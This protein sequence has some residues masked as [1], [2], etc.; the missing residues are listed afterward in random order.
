MVSLCCNLRIIFSSY[1]K[2][3]LKISKK[4]HTILPL[5]RVDN[6]LQAVHIYKKSN[7]EMIYFLGIF[8]MWFLEVITMLKINKYV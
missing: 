1:K 5:E 2:N 6:V 8:Y 3:K 7:Y 4:D